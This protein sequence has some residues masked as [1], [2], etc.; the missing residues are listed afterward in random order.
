[1]NGDIWV[2]I[3][4]NLTVLVAVTSVIAVR[5]FRT[6]DPSYIGAFWGIGFTQAQPAR[7]TQKAEG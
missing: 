3:G 4:I 5:S 6:K 7:A 1:M 2:L